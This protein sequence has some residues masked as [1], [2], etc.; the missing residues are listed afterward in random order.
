MGEIE[1]MLTLKT[2]AF[3]IELIEYFLYK[4]NLNIILEFA[5]GGDLHDYAKKFHEKKPIP[6]SEHNLIAWNI[7][8]GL[9]EMHN[10]KM[11]HRDIKP[12]NILIIKNSDDDKGCLVDI[13]LCDYGLGKKV[14]AEK[15]IE[16]VTVLG[17]KH[18]AAPEIDECKEH[19]EQG[20]ISHYDE[21]VDVWS[22]GIL[23]Y[24]MIFRFTPLEKYTL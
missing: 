23:L 3:T 10:L 12:N 8:C 21:K 9:N 4:N 6:L 16:G 14:E 5:N 18:Y 15:M 17:T 7:G 2:S 22:Y 19:T 13:K 11:M 24:Y 1:I 20:K